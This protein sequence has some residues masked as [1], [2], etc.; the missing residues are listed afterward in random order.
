MIPEL[1]LIL[2]TGPIKSFQK[3]FSGTDKQFSPLYT[4]YV[5]VSKLRGYCVVK[6]KTH[7]TV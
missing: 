6:K 7:F 1:V 3:T 5:L 2:K 4:I